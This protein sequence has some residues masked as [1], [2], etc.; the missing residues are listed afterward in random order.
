MSERAVATET[1]VDKPRR[2]G[3][4]RQFGR[5]LGLGLITGAA[6]D[7]PSAIGAYASAGAAIG[8]GFL[9]VA[10]VLL[11]MMFAVVYLSAKLGQVSGQGLFRVMRAHYGKGLLYFTLA[12]ALI[13]NAIE[14]AA[15]L[16]GM[17]AAINLYAP[18]PIPWLVAII[19]AIILALQ[20]FGSY[21]LIRNVFRWLALALLAYVAAA[22]MAKPDAREVLR[23][24]FLPH[25]EFS[26]EFLTIIVA[27][28]GSTLSAYI[29][30]W[31]S[32]EEV[33]EM[34]AEGKTT[35]AQRKGATDEELR[36]V[37]R[38]VGLGM[39]FSNVIMYFIILST[40]ATLHHSGKTEINSAVEAA[41]ALQPLAG[42]AAGLLFLLGMVG[43]GFLAVPVMT[44]GAAYDLAQTFGWRHSLHATPRQAKKFYAAIV[45]LTVIAVALNF[46]GVNP[47]K[48]LV[49][50]GVVQ[51]VSTPPLLALIVLMT[52]NKAIMGDKTNGLVIN[53]LA[54]FTILATSA[55]TLGLFATWI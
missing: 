54:G 8:A 25:V 30:S 45:I 48:A 32:N 13:G 53:I 17:A 29:Y 26:R 34:I 40:A 39:L 3:K 14:A 50:A 21:V 43:V 27:A 5:A 18:L 33:E 38:D 24:T 52:N 2:R 7:D 16:G 49:W 44:A 36:T 55:A 11:P 12:G 10:P 42:Q 28:I 19:A 35:L 23:G 4:A 51:G 1:E 9:W 41:Q 37:G 6:D 15:D 47:M 22:L 46:L 31:Q 20:L